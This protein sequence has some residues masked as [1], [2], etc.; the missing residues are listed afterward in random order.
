VPEPD[1]HVANALRVGEQPRAV[2]VRQRAGDHV[3]VR[4]A[5]RLEPAAPEA[6]ELDRVV[7]QFVVIGR[8][9]AA[10][11]R[12]V[13]L[14]RAQRG[15][16]LPAGGQP[17]QLESVRLGFAALDAQ[18]QRS[19]VEEAAPRVE[20]GRAHRGVERVNEVADD[21][22]GAARAAH[23]PGRLVELLEDNRFAALR[24]LECRQ[25]PGEFTHQVAARNPR[26]QAQALL[27]GR[28]RNMQGDAKQ[29][30]PRVVRAHGIGDHGQGI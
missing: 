23:E 13:D 20:K 11:P 8:L 24:R 9:I 12:R 2:E 28:L 21:Q 1:L 22:I 30:R 4:Y 27:A 16:D 17:T 26:R 15:P 10:P 19:G 25:M 5:V 3:L 29:M 18:A 6:A 14:Q 7:D